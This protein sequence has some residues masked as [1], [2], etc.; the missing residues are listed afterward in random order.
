VV[1]VSLGINGS[2][3]YLLKDDDILARSL[4][5]L[6]AERRYSLVVWRLPEG[7]NWNNVDPATQSDE[8]L[9]CAGSASRLVIELRRREGDKH[10]QYVVGSEPTP[11]QGMEPTEV[12]KWGKYTLKVHRSE[13]YDAEKALPLFLAYVHSGQLPKDTTRRPIRF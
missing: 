4:R 3:W 6:D 11:G 2:T 7:T 1:D 5:L 12:V 13:V 8:Y 10:A 9:Q